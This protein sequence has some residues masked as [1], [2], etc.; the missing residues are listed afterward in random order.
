MKRLN[1]ALQKF[2]A[3]T[4][5]SIAL[6]A[7]N[8]GNQTNSNTSQSTFKTS[9]ATESQTWQAV[10]TPG[11]SAG[12]VEF[13]SL[14]I[15]PDGTPY[16]AYKDDAYDGKVVVMKFD[17]KNWVSV[18]TP[19][20]SAG[21]ALYID[22]AIG[23]DGTPYITYADDN[24]YGQPTVLKFDGFNWV[25]IGPTFSNTVV[26]YYE[27]LAISSDGKL[28][29]AYSDVTRNYVPTVMEF[30]GKQWSN[31]DSYLF[32]NYYRTDNQSL[33]AGPNGALYLTFNT[34]A[35][36]SQRVITLVFNPVNRQWSTSGNYYDG[37]VGNVVVSS[38]G[39][40]YIASMNVTSLWGCGQVTVKT[41]NAKQQWQSE[42]NGLSDMA[43]TPRMAVSPKDNIQYITYLDQS[44]ANKITVM[45]F[46]GKNWINAGNQFFSDGGVGS[47]TIEVAPDGT[48]YVAYIDYAH[49]SRI[50]VMRLK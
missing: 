4:L 8:V 24:N 11:F 38:D 15:A 27:N 39:I 23:S 29:L 47:P 2:I 7:C 16:I 12:A 32:Y 37:T 9:I 21:W 30:D 22:L 5:F 6:T 46:D 40:P 28:Y 26:G 34:A 25:N 36:D 48:V 44:L 14:A 20:F 18:G 33:A 43:F 45:T 1:F 31:L 35:V 13:Q 42:G 17:G 41:L 10:G 50:T 49:G 3:A 19:G